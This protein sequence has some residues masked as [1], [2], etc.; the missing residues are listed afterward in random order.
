MCAV[1]IFKSKILFNEE[2]KWMTASKIWSTSKICVPK[3][4]SCMNLYTFFL[5]LIVMIRNLVHLRFKSVTIGA[6]LFF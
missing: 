1:I 2:E 6:W 5:H 4:K 3:G